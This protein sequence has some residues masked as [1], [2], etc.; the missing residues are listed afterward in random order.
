MTSRSLTAF[1]TCLAFVG[2][3]FWPY[4]ARAQQPAPAAPAAAPG[5]DALN[6]AKT[7]FEAGKNAYN[8]GDYQT[9]IREF[10]AAEAL[11]P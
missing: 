1:T 5:D 8:A 2:A 10:K 7:H 4:V 6:Q 11:R 9:S 3:L